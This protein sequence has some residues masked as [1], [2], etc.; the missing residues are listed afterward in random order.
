LLK[1]LN[2]FV[3]ESYEETVGRHK[4]R[5]K[6][7]Y[8]EPIIWETAERAETPAKDAP[9]APSIPGGPIRLPGEDGGTVESGMRVAEGERD[10]EYYLF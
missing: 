1:V 3:R 10:E 6:N 4:T 9:P 2:R 8:H 5:D 7:V